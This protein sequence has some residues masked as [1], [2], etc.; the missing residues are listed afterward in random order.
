[1]LLTLKQKLELPVTEKFEKGESMK[2]LANDYE[3]GVQTVRDIKKN[4]ELIKFTRN[5]QF[6]DWWVNEGINGEEEIRYL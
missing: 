2:K 4:K 1:M 5:C 6:N 3:I